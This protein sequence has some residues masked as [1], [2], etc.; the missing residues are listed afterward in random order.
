M[1]PTSNIPIRNADVPI[2]IN[3]PPV[4]RHSGSAANPPSKIPNPVQVGPPKMSMCGT[5][6]AYVK[7]WNS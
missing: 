2:G 4:T 3:P 5:D 1:N 7:V 6:P